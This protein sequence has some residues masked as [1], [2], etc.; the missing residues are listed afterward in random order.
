MFLRETLQA[1]RAEDWC[2]QRGTLRTQMSNEATDG[3]APSIFAIFRVQ[4]GPRFT[5]FRQRV[6]RIQGEKPRART[7]ILLTRP[8]APAR[9]PYRPKEPRTGVPR[10]GHCRPTNVQRGYRRVGTVDV[11]CFLGAARAGSR[12]LPP[13]SEERPK[14]RYH[15]FGFTSCFRALV[16]PDGDIACPSSNTAFDPSLEYSTDKVVL[17]WQPLSYFAPWSPSSLAVDDVPYSCVEKNMMAAKTRLFQYHRAVGPVMSSPSPS[18]RKPIGRGV[19]HFDPRVDD[20]EKQNAV[21]S[22]TYDKFTHNPT[23]NK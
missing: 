10:K 13:T 14:G 7:R 19:R 12:A 21:L 22:A 8:G 5:S 11:G 3:L 9:G 23:K 4:R 2:S 17:F 1:E 20:R 15:G 6:R 16:F 18:T